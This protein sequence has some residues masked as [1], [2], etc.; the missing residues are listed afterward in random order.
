MGFWIVFSLFVVAGGILVV[1]KVGNAN[2]RRK[3]LVEAG[4]T[5]TWEMAESRGQTISRIVQT[6]FGHGREVWVLYEASAEID[7][8]FRAFKTGVLIL[9]RPE[10]PDLREFCRSRHIELE[11]MMI[12]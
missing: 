12:K 2:K 10:A 5:S 8:K 4:R 9:P 11:F 3:H 1:V 7:R 6:D